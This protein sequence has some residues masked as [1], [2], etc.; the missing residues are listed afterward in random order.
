[1]PSHT[2][3]G[4]S[5]HLSR[6]LRRHGY[7]VH[8]GGCFLAVALAGGF[9]TSLEAT[10]GLPALL[11]IANGVLLAYLLL[12]PRWRWPAYAAVGFAAQFTAATMING[13]WKMNLFLSLINVFEVAVSAWLLRRRSN[14]LPQFSDKA[15]GWRFLAFGMIAGPMAAGLLFTPFAAFWFHGN[16][17]NCFLAWFIGDGLGTAV[18]TPACVALLRTHMREPVKGR[19]PW[20]YP[21]LLVAITCA[22][23]SQVRV[24][25]L[26]LV[27]PM[28]VLVLLRL[29]MAWAALGA[30]FVSVLGSYLTVHGYG[31]LI[32]GRTLTPEAPVVLLQIYIVAAMFMLYSISTVLDRKRAT[33]R[34]LREIVELHALVTENSRD[35]I[36]LA[37]FDGRRSYVS[38]ASMRMGGWKPEELMRNKSLDLV[39]PDDLRLAKQALIRLRSGQDE[40][41]IECRAR[42]KDG[43]YVWVE[44][45]LRTVRNP[46]TG[47]PSGILNTMRDISARKESEAELREAYRA[48]ESLAETDSLTHLANRRRFDQ[49]LSNEWR[50]GMRERTP[51]SMLLVDVDF[52][53]SFNDTYGHLHGDYCLKEIAQ[54]AREVVSRQGDLVARFGGEEFAI[55]LPNTPNQGAV[56]VATRLCAAV[57]LRKL[58][59]SGNP[60]G[61]LTVSVGCAT[62]TPSQGQYSVTLIQMADDA[63]YTAK[64]SGRNRI[65]NAN[66]ARAENLI[67]QAG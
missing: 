10:R 2:K 4:I 33:E 13:Q 21:C 54:A 44:A 67:A 46:A 26:F 29:G 55:V 16:P 66:A 58:T 62:I 27:Y 36:I 19:R 60:L 50:R 51:L 56:E 5:G 40:A 18:T 43:S 12:A 41:R 32:L 20:L 30:L 34:R 38:A 22:S 15:Y 57:R 1:M 6:W 63:M 35:V 48:L 7:A 8:L 17:A 45:N 9:V 3:H 28:L 47:V 39:H 24:P 31:P 59:H 42:K 49:H 11:W 64:K 37:D 61:Y 14:V 52:F 65:F 53:K 25:L 23:F